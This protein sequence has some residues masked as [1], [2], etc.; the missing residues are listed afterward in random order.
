MAKKKR[1]QKGRRTDSEAVAS[2][3]PPEATVDDPVEAGAGD[4]EALVLRSDLLSGVNGKWLIIIVFAAAV[5]SYCNTFNA[6]FTLDDLP[7]VAENPL[8]RSLANIPE[9]FRSNY[10][11]YSE[12][13]SD[14]SLYRPLTI[15]S[16]AI[17][18]AIHGLTPGGYHVVNVL[19]HAAVSVLMFVLLV[20]MFGNRC[21]AFVSAVIFA[22]HPIH[23]EAVSGVVGRAEIM[24]LLGT[25]LC[26]VT[27]EK[28][29]WASS[30]ST[31]RTTFMW[32]SFSVLAYF[33]GMCSKETGVIAPAVIVLAEMLIP[34][35]RF[36][37]RRHRNA[38]LLFAAYIGIACIYLMM[39][40]NAI[41][42]KNINVGFVDV[43]THHRVFTAL[44]VCLE[45][46]GLHVFPITLSADYW[47]TD[48][49]IARWPWEPGVAAA[50][51][52]LVGCL[53]VVV[54]C[55]RRLPAF[56]WGILIFIVT[57]APVSNIV[58]PIGVMK[59]E[60]ILYTPSF[61]LII[62][63]ASLFCIVLQKPRFRLA[64]VVF[65][66]GTVSALSMRTLKRNVDWNNNGN[67]ARATLKTSPNSP[68]FN[69]IMGYWYRE[70][71]R[72]AEAREHFMVTI[73]WNPKDQIALYNLGNIN[74]DEKRYEE[75]I[76]YYNKALELKPNYIAALNNLG[77][78]LLSLQRYTEGRDVFRRIVELQPNQPEAY[79]NLFSVHY[80]LKDPEPV[81][82]LAETAVSRFPNFAP[83]QLN[84]AAILK[85]GGLIAE[86]EAAS[87]RAYALDPNIGKSREI[88]AEINY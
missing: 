43:E 88:K 63:F 60:R 21:L 87:A 16:Y 84:A 31:G 24:A 10:W 76:S 64:M 80:V 26:C 39:R 55:W 86:A 5:L 32:G 7:I 22:V 46:V 61:G 82:E 65:L 36:L 71:G 1:P 25:V 17:N 81:L 30:A 52:V 47:I 27:Y 20:S 78:T 51:V 79:V 59:A 38:V 35:N 74:L 23:T 58:F 3:A 85:M 44:R 41:E 56:S 12:K 14:K 50:I 49:P 48:V 77:R 75:A 69:S 73:E 29:R 54:G 13:F 8:I 72:N 2:S 11:G 15:T 40:A 57:L 18:H 67:L 9:I 42:T 68:I 62:A 53:A 66:V 34:Q 33:S 6:G 70:R 83:L 37:F 4:G 19:L 45:Y 28:V